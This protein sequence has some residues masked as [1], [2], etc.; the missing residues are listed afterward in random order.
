M[1]YRKLGKS[2]I[3]VS[4]IGQGT[5]ALGND[6]FGAIDTERAISAIH[7]ALDKGVNLVDTA[8]AYGQNY[9]AEYAV[10]KALKGR[11]DKVVLSTKFGV[12]RI[13]GEYVRCLSPAVLVQEVENSLKRLQTDYIDVLFIHWPDLNFGIEGGLQVLADLK[14]QGKIRVAGVSNFNLEQLKTA[15]DI[16]DID[17][18]Q[19]PCNLL[20]R[21]YVDN[22]VMP[23]C[24][25]HNIGIMTYGSLGGGVLTGAFKELPA[26]GG[27]ESRGAFY[28]GFDPANWEKTSALINTLREVANNRGVSVGEVSINWTLAQPGVT[29]AL[30]GSTNPKNVDRNVVASDWDLTEEEL[31]VINKKY[32]ELFE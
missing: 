31:S 27:Q 8:P 19:P 20:D 14:K 16:A 25:E 28:K 4:V 18:I 29:T 32:A 11:R 24:A 10:G 13:M 12:H 9:E 15:I 7:E 2:G 17:C 6:F 22:G 30:L 26:V 1:K 21:S 3:D 5:W 23:F